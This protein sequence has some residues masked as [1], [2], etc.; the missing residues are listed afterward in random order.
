[1]DRRTD[2]RG[3]GATNDST[4]ELTNGLTRAS[5]WA[6][7]ARARD[8]IRGVASALRRNADGLARRY[9]AEPR[10]VGIRRLAAD[11]VGDPLAGYGVMVAGTLVASLLVAVINRVWTPLPSPGI[12][13]L[14]LVAMLAYHWGWRPALLAAALE[15]ACVYVF[16]DPPVG[17]SKPATPRLAEQVVTLA[18]V[19]GFVL[20]LVQLARARRE[21]AEREAGRFAALNRVGTALAGE[22]DEPR[23]L[24]L[25]ARTARE[26]T[27]AHFAAFTLR[28]VDEL[29]RPVGESEGNLFHLAAVVG[30]TAR[31]EE[32]FRRV[33]LGG[34]GILAPIFRFGVPVRVADALSLMEAGPVHGPL[35][36]R[37][38]TAA[39]GDAAEMAGPTRPGTPGDVEAARLVARAYARGEA[40]AADLHAVGVPRGHPMVRSFLGA[41]LLDSAG[42][43]RGGLLLGHDQPNRFTAEDEALLTGLAAQASVALENARLY[44]AAQAQARELD[45]IF[46]SIG[47]GIAVV[48]DRGGV[49]RENAAARHLRERLERTRGAAA[50]RDTLREA[51][52]AGGRAGSDAG[53]MPIAVEETQGEARDF[54][55]TVSPLAASEAP[56]GNPQGSITGPDAAHVPS[57]ATVVVW[58]DVTTARRLDQERLARADAEARRAL[59]QAVVDEL[60]SGVYLV[61]G[62]DACLVLANRAALG[63]WGAAWP[64]GMRMAEFLE[65]S[66]TRI[67][68][69]DGRQ[70]GAL[71]L[72]TV[73]ALRG[74]QPIRHHQEVIRHPDGTALPILLNAVPFDPSALGLAPPAGRAAVDGQRPASA[75]DGAREDATDPAALVVLQ[76]VTAL[77]EAERLK[78]D[79]I[80]IAA[81][82]LRNPMAA[83]RGY[84]QLL[85]RQQALVAPTA[86]NGAAE[87]D[88][89]AE[90]VE[91][92]DQAT[93]RLVELTD[94]LLDVT[95]LQGG[96]LELHVEPADLAGLARRVARRMGV[97]TDRHRIKVDADPEFVVAAIDPKRIEQVL[98]NLVNN[99]V[100]YSPDGG[101]VCLRVRE[102]QSAGAAEV[103]VIDQGIGIPADQRARIFGRFARAD[104]ARERGITGTGLGL[105]LSRELVERQGG[106]IWFESQEGH[107]TTFHVSLP[108]A[109]VDDE[110][111]APTAGT[112]AG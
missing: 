72:A 7:V 6:T 15:L 99:G 18:A 27:G 26:L 36:M 59:L 25:I 52:R 10:I 92:I 75:P 62:R 70:L 30:V 109:A 53:G 38:A 32:L 83:L 63:V 40:N 49:L 34:E 5:R 86:G 110:S 94:D 31:Q 8:R 104:N 57:S 106:R 88:V 45:T 77:K 12:V 76:D 2:T 71:D 13:Y 1:M 20:A 95:R 55:I 87:D 9:W 107:G 108:L 42:Q 3:H 61:H 112:A 78:D 60:P 111:D 37:A 102:D 44:R 11:S 43:V 50:V 66:G 80:G 14:P 54:V 24:D 84:A 23:L 93:L 65:A 29:G 46:E 85:A 68:G 56:A 35:T 82:E 89:R 69:A 79:F 19:T 98:T 58:H 4:N 101:E 47:D 16:F 51:A 100:K 39:E 48:D 28:P 97:T 33:P 64:P 91:A 81:H 67:F 22:L 17:F 74:G 21:Q 103:A 105:Y 90:A 73:R 41:P 96:R